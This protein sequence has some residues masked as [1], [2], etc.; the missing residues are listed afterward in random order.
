MGC[1]LFKNRDTNKRKNEHTYQHSVE[2]TRNLTVYEEK[3]FYNNFDQ[4]TDIV[5]KNIQNYHITEKL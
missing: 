1:F 4:I 2:K 3:L 5:L